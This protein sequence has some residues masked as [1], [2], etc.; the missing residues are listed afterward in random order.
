MYK[1]QGQQADGEPGRR[2]VCAVRPEEKSDALWEEMRTNR[3]LPTGRACRRRR[4]RP[5]QLDRPEKERGSVLSSA[6]TYLTLVKDPIIAEN[7]RRSDFRIMDLMNHERP[8]S[9]YIVTRGGDKERL[10]PLV[11]LLL[12][13]AMRQLMGVELTVQG[14]P[15][16][17]AAPASAADDAGRVPLTGPAADHPGR[18]AEMRRLRHQGVPRGAEP[19]ADVQ[20]LR[21]ITR[22]S[23]A[24]ATSASCMRRTSGNRRSGSA[25]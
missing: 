17:D 6:K 21:R 13:M 14:R 10:R 25:A 22:A 3:H 11:R 1:A 4:R 2:G 15:A 9:L 16:A 19:R 20:R 24:T 5:R 8:V 7:T 18:A 12:T 23:P